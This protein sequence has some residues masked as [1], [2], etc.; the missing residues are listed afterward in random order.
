MA[1]LAV[2][3]SYS[4]F[5]GLGTWSPLSAPGLSCAPAVLRLPSRFPFPTTVHGMQSSAK[6]TGLPRGAPSVIV[7][8]R[9]GTQ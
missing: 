3:A 2:Q 9:S 8:V 6:A 7:P 1:I 4:A 5:R